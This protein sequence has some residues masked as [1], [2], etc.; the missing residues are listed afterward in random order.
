MEAVAQT[1]TIDITPECSEHMPETRNVVDEAVEFINEKKSL[2]KNQVAESSYK[3]FV[4]IGEYLLKTF[5]NNDI[6]LASSKDEDKPET[7]RSLAK[8]DDLD[9]HYTTLNKMVRC[10]IQEKFLLE[11]KDNIDINNNNFT[12][13]HRLILL[14]L[15]DDNLKIEL[16]K[17]I[18]TTNMSTR[19]LEARVN[20]E[21]IKLLGSQ[22]N[23]TPRIL[24]YINNLIDELEYPQLE[25]I[26]QKDYLK[27][28]PTAKREKIREEMQ[29]LID[30]MTNAIASYKKLIEQIDSL[31]NYQPEKAKKGRPK[32]NSL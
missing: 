11:H 23:A 12:Y 29:A 13:T 15:P 16:I 19:D 3:T 28:V 8:R 24:K 17:E 9:V 1:N 4:E 27:K 25:A 7:Y 6:A 18:N 20:S 26:A 2:L 14:R 21:K 30:K 32:K 22:R 10:A 5:F 31:K